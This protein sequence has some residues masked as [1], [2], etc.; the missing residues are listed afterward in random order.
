MA[1]AMTYR[2]FASAVDSDHVSNVRRPES[3][4]DPLPVNVVFTSGKTTRIALQVAGM[5]VK[6]LGTQIQLIVPELVPL[7]FSLDSPPVAV[8]FLKHRL[9]ELVRTTDT[10]EVE[11]SIRLWLCRDP[12][13]CVKQTLRPHSVVLLGARNRSWLNGAWR[14]SRF[15]ADIGHE[16]IVVRCP[17]DKLFWSDWD[18]ETFWARAVAGFGAGRTEI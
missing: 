6:G 10:C 18:W 4:A 2:P 12:F 7:Q 16:V 14:W 15:L 9:Y 3:K 13:Q 11:V 17:S 5:L 1:I 8:E